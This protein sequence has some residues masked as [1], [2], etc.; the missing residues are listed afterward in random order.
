MIL[1][2][3]RCFGEANA[4][5]VRPATEVSEG[6]KGAGDVRLNLPAGEWIVKS[7]VGGHQNFMNQKYSNKQ[8]IEAVAVS[9]SVSDV[10]RILGISINS[11][12]SHAHISRRIKTLKLDT[13]HFKRKRVKYV[14]GN[15]PRSASDVLVL[16]TSGYQEHTKALRRALLETGRK[17]ECECGQGTVW[18]GRPLTLQIEHINGNRLDD[19]P[20]NLTF[21]CPNCHTQ[22]PTWGSKKR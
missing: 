12:T 13:S 19:R 11:G 21:L 18:Q 15:K 22:T 1:A 20:E 8:L 17:E 7:E 14:G 9:E 16:K 2:V 10:L 4:V 5:C 3:S 6:I